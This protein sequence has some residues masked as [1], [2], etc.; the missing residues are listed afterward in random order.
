MSPTK[1][2]LVVGAAA[3][4]LAAAPSA[5]AAEPVYGGTTS[6]H[7]PIVLKADADGQSVTSMVIGWSAKC[8]DGTYFFGGGRFAATKKLPGIT[9]ALGELVMSRNAKGKFTGSRGSGGFAGALTTAIVLDVAGKIG[10]KKANGTLHAV[11]NLFDATTLAPAGVCDTGTLRFSATRSPGVVYGGATSQ[12]EP[13]V[14]RVD[15]A[16]RVVSNLL[17]SW[18]TSTCTPDGLMRFPD[19]MTGFPLKSTGAFGD[20]FGA[21]YTLNGGGKRHFDYQVA[22]KVTSKAV[23]GTLHVGITDA[24]PAGAQALSCDSGGITFKAQTG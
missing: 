3:A 12:Q 21:D 4:M 2:L 6:D 10:P 11:V 18:H 15:G 5:G 1:P 14:V 17:A 24:D 7:E 20:T 19:S 9:P 16:R 13:V 23:K 22:G 8:E